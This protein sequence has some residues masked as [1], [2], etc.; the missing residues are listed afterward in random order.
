MDAFTS[1]LGTQQGRI[2]KEDGQ[3]IFVLGAQT[4]GWR[5][6]LVVGDFVEVVQD[7]DLTD[8]KLV[9]VRGELE[10]RS[11]PSHMAWEAAL[12]IDGVRQA[13][14]RGRPGVAR[15]IRDLAACVVG[16]LGV[17]AVAVRLSLVEA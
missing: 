10:V 16:L 13:S 7:A 2:V 17:H 4:A 5:A 14:I 3:A 12:L 15:P 8:V 11:V 9:R 6:D 1:Q